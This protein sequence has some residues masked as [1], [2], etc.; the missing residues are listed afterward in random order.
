MVT[1]R[2]FDINVEPS[3]GYGER[4]DP[5]KDRLVKKVFSYA[6]KILVESHFMERIVQ[7]AGV[8]SSKIE[9]VPGGVDLRDLSPDVNS[10]LV[11]EAYSIGSRPVIFTMINDLSRTVKGVEYLL[12]TVP[13]VMEANQDVLFLIGGS[14]VTHKLLQLTRD[15]SIVDNVLFVGNIPRTQA[16]FFFAAADVVAIPSIMEAAPRVALEAMASSR[17]VIAT[18]VGGVPELIKDGINGFL[19]PSRDSSAMAEKI[20]TLLRQTELKESFG[21]EG[22]RVTVNRFD[23]EKRVNRIRSIYIDVLPSHTSLETTPKNDRP[24]ATVQI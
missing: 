20:V 11:R 21:R 18:E 17:A 8:D 14:H 24:T 19:V 1:T 9:L 15:L 3:I 23:I 16:R 7:E 10:S 13:E 12:K 6:E 5:R 22:R 4:L 2:G